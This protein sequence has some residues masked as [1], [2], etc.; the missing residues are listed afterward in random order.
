MSSTPPT[1]QPEPLE[2]APPADGVDVQ[3]ALQSASQAI[4]SGD[5]KVGLSKLAEAL[6]GVRDLASAVPILVQA[7]EAHRQAPG[8]VE[9][10]VALFVRAE[11][12]FG[13]TADILLG[14]ADLHEAAGH[15]EAAVSALQ[16]LAGVVT[17]DGR[18]A[19]ILERMGDLSAGP[20]AQPQ[21]A[22]IH[23]QAAFRADRKNR[24]AVRKA[25]RIYLDQGR[26]EQAKQLLDLEA[27]QLAD[28]SLGGGDEAT[29]K[30]IAE[31]YLRIAETLLVR[32]S[33]HAVA[34]DA[35]VRAERLQP[36][37][38]RART[39][40]SDVDAFPQTWKDHVRRLRDAALDARDKREAARRYLA[41]AQVY[42]AY[43]P[44]DPQIDQN[45]EK[46]L[47][48][49]PGYRPALKFLEGL[50]R[51][52]GKLPE[53]IERLK[54]QAEAVRAVDVAVDMWLFVALLLAERGSPPDDVAAAYE[55]VRRVDPRNVAAI[56]ALTE[57]HLEQGRYDKAAVVMEAFLQETSDLTAK[58]ATLR[59]LA[60]LYEAEIKDHT[61][62]A[63]RLEQLH[64]LEPDDDGVV[65]QLA[66][67]YDRQGQEPKLAEMLEEQ[68]KQARRQDPALEARLLERLVGLYQGGLAAPDKAFN[69]AR[70]L[71]VLQPRESLEAELG[72]LGDAL[73]RTGD[74]AQTYLE[75]AQRAP[76]DARRLRVR[77]AQLFL[78][79][80]DRK[81]ARAVIDQLLEAD[82][83]DKDAL[84]LL[85]A[86]MARDASPEEH[87]S[88]LEG[89]LKASDDPRER[90]ATLLA[91]ADVLTKLRRTDDAVARLRE[92][93]D[94]DSG[95]RSAHEKLEALLKQ[96]ER[97]P[98]LAEALE[99]RVRVEHDLAA[100]QPAA[101]AEALAA[102]GRL[103]RIYEEKLVRG[104][105]AA[106]LYLRLHEAKARSGDSDVEV[107]RALERFLA[108]GTH[109]VPIAE[110]LQ[111]Y[112][113]QVGAF[114]KQVEMMALRHGAEEQPQRRAALAQAMAGILE[115]RLRAPREAFDAW[116]EA[117]LDQPQSAEVLA[118]CVR[119]AQVA[120]AHARF[121]EV[122]AKAADRLP[123]G[124]Q[125]NQ[126]MERR[127]QLLDGVLGDQASAI[128]AHKAILE[129]TPDALTSL[130]AL[131]DIYAKR[132]AWTELVDVLERRIAAT[133]PDE[134]GPFA[135][136]LGL[137]LA[138]RL[139]D[140]AAARPW[141]EQALKSK[142]AP[143]GDAR[144]AALRL[145]IGVYQKARDAGDDGALD[146]LAWAL[147]EMASQLAGKERSAARAELGDVLRAQ[148]KYREALQAY[149]AA[150]AND[151]GQALAL[152]GIRGVLDDASA[153]TPERTAAARS[154]L[155][156]YDAQGNVAGRAHVL[157]VQLALEQSPQVRRALVG[158]IATLFVEQ[159]EQPDE[160]FTLQ[161]KQLAAD[162]EDEQARVNVEALVGAL[163]RV[164]ELAAL[165]HE[166]RAH[167]KPEI[168]LR[169]AERLAELTVQRGDL[170]G[171]IEALRFI[172][173]LQ[174]Q[175]KGPWERMAALCERRN[176][177]PGLATCIEKLAELSTGPQRLAHLLDLAEVYFE[178]LEDD[179]RGLDTL[180]AAHALAP[181]DDSVLARL[182][183]RLRLG[184][185]DTPELAAVLERRA[186]LQTNPSQKAAFL[187]ELGLLL[188]RAS[189]V[190]GAVAA[191]TESLRVERDGNN[192]AR[193]SEALQRIASR[194]DDAGRQALDAIIEHHRAQKAWQPLVD[195]LEIAATKRATGEER[196]Q[197]L[198]EISTM[199]ESALR[200]PQLAFMA[201]SRA[202]RDAPTP[203]RLARLTALAEQTEAWP[204]LLEVLE[205]VAE[206]HVEHERD[207][208]VHFLR[209]AAAV[210]E[211]IEDKEAQVRV[212]E[213]LLRLDP[214][215][216]A[217]L[218]ALEK[219][220]RAEA[221]K[222]ALVEVLARRAATATTPA[223]RRDALFE[224]ARLLFVID[225]AGA[226]QALRQILEMDGRDAEALKALDDLYE[227]TGN[228]AALAEV[229]HARIE[230]EALAEARVTLR[231]RLAV[232]LLRRRG[233][234]AGALDV[235]RAAVREAPH[236]QDLRPALEVLVEHARTRGAP[237]VGDAA[238]LLEDVLR[239]QGDLA[240]VPQM[241]ELRLSAEPDHA[242]RATLLLEIAQVQ[243]KLGQPAL[244]FMTICRAIKE[245]PD[246]ASLRAEA[247]RLAGV[248]DNLEALA[249]VYEDV[250]DSARDSATRIAL[251][252][253][254]AD[255]AERVQGEP[256]A[257]RERLLAAVQAGAD[258]VETLQ[259]L[260][261]LT[262]RANRA[263]DMSDALGRLAAAAARDGNLELAKETLGERSDV[264][265][266]LGNL[267]GAIESARQVL[268]HDPRDQGARVTLER[269]YN[270]GERWP[271]L[272][273]LLAWLAQ[274]APT[275]EER[276]AVLA[277][278]VYL[279][280][281]RLRDFAGALQSLEDLAVAG[282]SSESITALGTR[283]LLLLS[284]DNRPDAVRLRGQLA[285]LLEPRFEAAAAWGD[286]G[287]VLRLRLDVER[288]PK[289]RKRL[290]VRIIDIEERML[291]RPEQAMVTLARALGE[292]PA[293][294][295]LRDRA[296]RLSVRLHDL[297][298]LLGLYEDI[299]EALPMEHPQRVGYAVRCGELY[300][301][302]VGQP[303]RA[304]EFYD[305]GFQAATAQHV[306]DGE[307]L[308]LLERIERLYRVSGE[309]ARLATTLKRKAELVRATD[310]NAA[311][312]FLS[313]AATLEQHQLKDFAA[314][315][316]TL[317]KVLELAPQDTGALRALADACEREGRWPEV[318][319]ALE[320]ELAALPSNDRAR[321]LQARFQLGMVLDKHLGLGEEALIQ[322][323][324]V[325]QDAPDHKETREYLENRIEQRHTGKFDG[326][327]YLMQSYERTGDFEK[328]VEIL[329][330]QVPETERQGDRKA[331][332]TLLV[333][334][335]DLH[336]HKLA[337]PDLAF[338]TLC[339]AL[340]VDPNDPNLRERLSRLGAQADVTDELCE[341]YEEEALSAE[342]SG[343]NALASELREAAGAAL[344]A[345][346]QPDKA[347]AI[348]EAVLEK[349]PGRLVPLDALSTLYPRVGRHADHERVLRR[350][351]MFKDEPAERVPILV[352]LARSLVGP[353]A[354]PDEAMPV[355]DEVR[356]L[357]SSNAGARALLIDQLEQRGSFEALRGLLDEEVAACQEA[358][359]AEGLARARWRMAT[360]LA[361]QLNDV[362]AAIPLWEALRAEATNRSHTD[363]TFTTLE[364]LYTTAEKW[365]ELK[366]MYEGALA[367]ERDPAQV[368]ALTTKVG[369]VLVHLGS[370]EEAVARHQKVLELDPHNLS[371]LNALRR[372]YGDLGR[373]EE[374]VALIR[375]MMRT[376]T[377]TEQLKDLRFQLAETLGQRLG[378][379][380]EAIETGR[381][382]LDIEPH[383]PAQLDR[384][385]GI[386]RAGE[387]WEELADVLEKSAQQAE[388]R[389]RVSKLIELAS[390]FE[391]N[392]RRPALAAGPYERILQV[393]PR[394]ERAYARL[395]EI[396]TASESWQKLV[397]VKEE[398]Q[399]HAPDVASK[400]ALLQEIGAIY[401]DKLGQQSLAFLAACRAFRE[402]YDDPSLATWMDRLA[403][404]TD[405]ADELVTIYDDA[406]A[407]ITD[408]RRIVDLHL[409]M[410]ELAWKHLAS[411]ADAELHFKR[412]LEYDATSQGA[413]DGMVALF[414]S[415]ERWRDVVTMFE[416]RAEQASDAAGRIEMLR[417]VA[418][419]LDDKAH[420]VEGAIGAYKRILELDGRDP[421]ATRDLA[422]ILE[423]TERWQQLVA[424]L[425]RSEELCATTEERMAVRMRTAAIWEN[426][427]ASVEQA[428]A[429]YRSIL[430]EEPG[431][432]A[433]LRALERLFTNLNRPQELVQIF[434]KLV[435][436]APGADEAVHLL[437][438][439]GATWEEGLDDTGSAIDANRRILEVD[440]QNVKAAENL[441]R[442]YRARKQWD[443]LVD[444]I[445]KHIS[446]VRDPQE[447]VRLYVELGQVYATELD[448]TDKAEQVYNAALDFDP[449]AQDAIHA[450]GA[451]YEKSGNWFN[452]LEKL[453]AEA[454]L[455]GAS[456]EA[457]EIYHRIGTINE[458]MLLDPGNAITAYKAALDIEPGHVPSI[459]ALKNIAAQRG[460]NQE[461]LHWLRAEATYT[462]D[463]TRRTELHTETGMFLQDTLADLEGAEAEFEKALAITFDHLPAARPLADIAY[464][465]EK[466]QR[467]EQLLDIIVERLDP[468]TDAAELC[469]QHYRLGYVC[470]RLGHESKGL[471]NY[472]RAYELDATYLPGLEGLG[473][474]LS[475]A[476]RWEDAAKV[477][478]AILIHHRDGLTDAEVVDYYQ[479]LADLNHKLGQDDRATKNLEK[480]LELDP[481]HPPSL[482]LLANVHLAAKNV[483]DAYETL[484]RL[485]PLVFGDERSALL[486]EIGRLGKG[487]LDDPYR[488]IDA[489]EDANRQKP[490]DKEILEA[491]LGLYRQTRQGPRAV[492]VLEE[493]VRVEQ[494]EKARVRLNQTL[495]EVYRDEIKNEAR[496]VQYFNAALDLDP[497]FVRAFESIE[498]MLSST[499]NWPALEENYIAM[500]KRI[501]DTRA[502]IKE[503][504]WKNLGDLY[505]FRLRSLEGATQA[506]RVVVKM[507][508]DSAENVEVLADLL[509]RNPQT[510]DEAASAYQRLLTLSPQ[511]AGRALHELLRIALAKKALDRA[512]VYA[513][514]LKVRGEAQ[515]SEIEVMQLY[516]KQLPGQPKR[517]MTDK[518]WDNLLLHPAARSPVAAISAILWRTAGSV[519]AYQPKDYGLDKKRATDWERVDLDAP[520]QSYFVNQLKL[521]R[522]VLATGGFELYAKA[523]S[524]EPLSPLCLE[525]PTLAMG[526]ASPLLGETNRAR[527]W[528]T[529]GRQLCALRPVFVLPR[530]LGAQRFN[531]LVDVAIRFVDPRYPARGDP[532]ELQRFEA[533]LSRLGAPLQNALRPHVM[534]L[535]KLKQAVNTKPFLEGMEH[536]AVRAGYV[537]TGDIE[538]CATLTKM[539]DPAA[540]PIRPEDKI[541]ELLRF[542]VSDEGFE[543]RTRL[544]TAIGS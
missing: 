48:L 514:A 157:E 365:S 506:Y 474:A 417:R 90:A 346:D 43:A 527:L 371:S 482:R 429:T 209:D 405:S 521:V 31:L 449:G 36:E 473:S 104:D 306:P 41:I 16:R 308:K 177:A 173:S 522:G 189:D 408:E 483:E 433:A 275:P 130:D 364:R 186:L 502:G 181:E 284:S 252:K 141:L 528:F 286:L 70:R 25:A 380:A 243:E 537:L 375:K 92:V 202:L 244:G 137:V 525:Q 367:N 391:E 307:R 218:N 361:E 465:D 84:A 256:E 451:L 76:A 185:A 52:E 379:R 450:L 193:T 435:A 38:A 533:A 127:A 345:T 314:A 303:L 226:E 246:D 64:E 430:D 397:A 377:H 241:I 409:R 233:D 499:G 392:L 109:V 311:R 486:M 102:M 267:T 415:Q 313:E 404:A 114:R 117:L 55:K 162:P 331:L 401:E 221:D 10:A 354:R 476:G 442:L 263:E 383:T 402:N 24:T 124:P 136:R 333:R 20:L 347:I 111:P 539:P 395:C 214:A 182:E 517:A 32:P 29:R 453:Q 47:L 237:P 463:E 437:F 184:H 161:L 422:E 459:Q 88:V 446:F 471:K 138:E 406:L 447:I 480:A 298:S 503:V 469:R 217:A 227:R 316:G 526:K 288:D 247:E 148:K 487:D 425:R 287:P 461:R 470:E 179:P 80:G 498:T 49:S 21:Q 398:R 245:L 491:L 23:Y 378:K 438:K 376:T 51:D 372:L 504:L 505:R 262:R 534:E 289:E 520:V 58:K 118:E 440:P 424:V 543:L 33:A 356:R 294:D 100:G 382:I 296:E 273:E 129:K 77:A 191:L 321:S 516:A 59:Q 34:R 236:V 119:L 411:P 170:D 175:S 46:C 467:A 212:A 183:A 489:F 510:T 508:P 105:D 493:L 254:I 324:A 299:I 156:K 385:A 230:F 125:K 9:N 188:L 195:S 472:Q 495:G 4:A 131:A 282:P 413:L 45:V 544:G 374:L 384:L 206:A 98:E 475:R 7:L 39:L 496:A 167:T 12:R 443:D 53:F 168:A 455:L 101:E 196:A 341:L 300:E 460:D 325:L 261:R 210:A 281:E 414:E 126:M 369:E 420:D 283:A 251:H 388:G 35:A 338:M 358:G 466:W 152:A 223:A 416:R 13:S 396:A 66:E 11:E 207:T 436:L 231:A 73:A 219:V 205:D 171:A 456:K 201:T 519:L 515:P 278:L 352:E 264:D 293:D 348:Y 133:S 359:D 427:L 274:E 149:E 5:A 441:E 211:R 225:D 228:S 529:I 61:K 541:A 418:R 253:R 512:Y 524:A 144:N 71:F 337:A 19:T 266:Q 412:A 142:K 277:R 335:A 334:I 75:A 518:L 26:E 72:R 319:E 481:S 153:S 187:T 357:D 63:E 494:D 147:S 83:R 248:T 531:T 40:Q 373:N 260:V 279:Q 428:I 222:R 540:I 239:A 163:G 535:L 27:E 110:A 60:R 305:L 336:E 172:A 340:R 250:L 123:D 143:T 140:V 17:D 255:V 285:V 381:R 164:E 259:D 165:Y 99:R 150:L 108:R 2:L 389:A 317:N 445:E 370:K 304:A 97:W 426:Q 178:S 454:Q 3:A 224:M 197:L 265:E 276:A 145:L 322:F 297:E 532:A 399:K 14:R 509:A 1:A 85:D 57:L 203:E 128:D 434:E 479:Q 292:D 50:A 194:D 69:A 28:P 67:L 452:A 159:L 121:A 507:K 68:L 458:Q 484:M 82:A 81:R 295:K 477:Y 439:I 234:P 318:A 15:H 310:V 62:A 213:A 198:D 538:L 421:A 154:L 523:N 290:W 200:V 220:H 235:L 363:V 351:L 87:A 513:Q 387:A 30:D 112:Y 280:L 431:H 530:T 390:L 107:L 208:A 478:Q 462:E 240:G 488:A 327:I 91:L 78:A 271:E 204:D 326:A 93:L 432:L 366:A 215:D 268:T 344:A 155:Q 95:V 18:K 103:A 229:L 37:L 343:K 400:I 368:S 174:P 444:I 160:A 407:Q 353:L 301:G 54:K 410:A 65:A 350:R 500:L 180:R 309:L 132:D 394:H 332:F 362:A 158:Q 492:E 89:R 42:A 22:L 79:A 329:Q 44:N 291:D 249:L 490:G 497:N 258:D 190:G 269:L 302:G 176:D 151:E 323:Q 330:A 312:H 349:Q 96:H 134:S 94:L 448:R 192:T 216:S 360:L 8:E 270:R 315:I 115:D 113:A 501:P 238:A 468:Q 320:R 393:E 423:R 122:L 386:F 146:Q 542:A 74:L 339:R 403:L 139:D 536:T 511:K 342:M 116:A 199:H 6:G 120:N 464:R 135:A 272:G 242:S 419:T 485:V 355:L 169:Y 328:A 457:V 86:L 257:A 106:Q 56:H 166:L 232:L